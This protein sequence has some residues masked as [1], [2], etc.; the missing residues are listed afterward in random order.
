MLATPDEKCHWRRDFS[1][2]GDTASTTRRWLR[3][4][5][6]EHLTRERLDTA[7]LLVE[8]IIGAS[9]RRALANQSITVLLTLEADLLRVEVVEP[10]QTQRPAAVAETGRPTGE[11]MM[12]ARNAR[13]WGMTLGPPVRVWFEV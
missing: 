3:S 2:A 9:S 7:V 13:G 12:V 1:L 10:E 4:S 5:L 6:S 11:L 8:E